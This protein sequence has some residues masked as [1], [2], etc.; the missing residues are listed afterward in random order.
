MALGN[1]AGLLGTAGTA[2]QAATPEEQEAA[3]LKAR[4]ADATA[5]S[6]GAAAGGEDIGVAFGGGNPGTPVPGHPG[7]VIGPDGQV[8]DLGVTNDAYPAGTTATDLNL[9]D[10]NFGNSNLADAAGLNNLG[11][12]V[13]NDP[14]TT[15][16]PGTSGNVATGVAPLQQ[17]ATGTGTI[18]GASTPHTAAGTLV[19]G[20]ANTSDLRSRDAR[21]Y[22]YGRD[23]GYGQQVVGQARTQAA[24]FGDES[25]VQ[26]Q[27]A[28]DL[29]TQYADQ[30]ASAG[31]RGTEVGAGTQAALNNEAQLAA[32]RGAA[33]NAQ[34]QTQGQQAV[35]AGGAINTNL[36][37]SGQQAASIGT[38]GNQ[39]IGQAG[40]TAA[41]LGTAGNTALGYA[42][43]TAAN[44]GGTTNYELRGAGQTAA[45]IGGTANTAL[46]GLEGTEGPSAAQATLNNATSQGMGDA[47]TLARS[48]RGPGGN[49]AQVAQATARIPGMAASA[50]NSAAT[51]RANEN[52]LWRQRQ[53]ANLTSGG[54]L[55]LA[56]QNANITA[57]TA[58]GEQ[59]LAG[60]QANIGAQTAGTQAALAGQ[61]ANIGAQTA[62]TQA[63]LEGQ[64]A[65]IGAQTAG[66]Q[67][68]MQGQGLG[69]D[70]T[71]AGGEAALAGRN[72]SIGAIT[73]GGSQALTGTAQGLEG[74]TAGGQLALAGNA[75]QQSATQNAQGQ[76]WQGESLADK[77]TGAQTQQDLAYE[78]MLTQKQGIDAGIAIN[79][80]NNEQSIW[81]AV[82]GAGATGLAMMAS[83]ERN[84]DVGDEVKLSSAIRGNPYGRTGAPGMAAKNAM[85]GPQS[86]LSPYGSGPMGGQQNYAA[87]QGQDQALQAKAEKEQEMRLQAAIQRLG[88]IAQGAM[89]PRQNN[90]QA[91]QSMIDNA[92]RMQ[93]VVS[94]ER[95]KTKI[96]DLE[97]QLA[98]ARSG[99]PDFTKSPNYAYTYKDPTIPGAAPGPQVGPMAQDLEKAGSQAV[100]NTPTGKM[101]DPSRL[102]METAGAVGDLQRQ[103]DELEAMLKADGKRRPLRQSAG[104]Y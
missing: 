72:A 50:A 31:Q 15:R 63:A 96:A 71:K 37:R 35:G 56:G 27:T 8:H 6:T 43:K 10:K 1:M 13:T 62:G 60:Q 58:G 90:G 16:L 59:A 30:A 99:S 29:G 70:A 26:G 11:E 21:D 57:Q 48:G 66:G 41:D 7:M 89:T 64:N 3:L 33:T 44:I 104:A 22:Q 65:N 94:D 75:A 93:P 45:D 97:G 46:T 51:L 47:L 80:A 19:P 55:A 67:V 36:T 78:N 38:T 82:I 73:A 83:D 40:Q 88:G 103:F 77:V 17:N 102:T 52:A 53:A 84:K 95:S 20:L 101:V 32:A 69:I 76:F 49:A 9:F 87:A 14:T 25:R 28:A 2:Y 34:L 79:A 100:M 91:G 81:P 92:M 5:A 54:Q 61:Q 24:A 23:A 85:K 42:G 74:A 98:A 18:A 86:D 12:T 4:Q 39:V 68:L